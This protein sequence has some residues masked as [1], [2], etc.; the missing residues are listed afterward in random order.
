[1][2]K[3]LWPDYQM[4]SSRRRTL[5]IYVCLVVFVELFARDWSWNGI[6]IL[7]WKFGIIILIPVVLLL[8]M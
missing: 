2:L 4:D 1:V 8:Q 5:W 6:S 3:L 7:F